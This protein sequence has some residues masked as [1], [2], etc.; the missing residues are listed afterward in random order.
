MTYLLV[1]IRSASTLTTLNIA[2]LILWCRSSTQR[3]DH[4]SLIKQINAVQRN[5]LE[6]IQQSSCGLKNE[7]KSLSR[8]LES[9]KAEDHAHIL[10]DW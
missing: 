4:D 10:I 7:V 9:A 3:F 6:A 1:H 5:I 2:V 8:T